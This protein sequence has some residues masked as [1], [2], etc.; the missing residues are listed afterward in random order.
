VSTQSDDL[1]QR[2]GHD[3]RKEDLLETAL[4]HASTQKKDNNYERLEFLGDRVLGLIVAEMIYNAYPS[5]REGALAKRLTALVQQSA[6]VRV[7]EELSLKDHVRLSAG[8]KKA[9]GAKKQTIMAD[10]V[11]ALI[12]ALY[13][14]GGLQAATAFIEKF[15]RGMLHVQDQPPE[16][17]KTKLQEW[18]QAQGLPLPKYKVVSQS[19]TA[20]SPVFTVSVAVDTQD[21]MEA[22]AQ[23]KRAAE[24]AA[25]KLM[26]DKVTTTPTKEKK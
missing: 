12:G 11:E 3:F 21:S 25:A 19:G 8:E 17:P 7:A 15:W 26:L 1:Q 18:A 10:A 23:S 6:L 9:G 24:K 5:E 16:D 13:L 20:H 2:I 4:T 22:T 14:D